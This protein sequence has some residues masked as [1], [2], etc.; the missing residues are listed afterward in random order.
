M[1]LRCDDKHM[2]LLHSCTH[3]NEYKLLVNIR[4]G[5]CTTSV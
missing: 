1:M 3:R 4:E 5:G 2:L